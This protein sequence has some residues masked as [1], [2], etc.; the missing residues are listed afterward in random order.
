[1]LLEPVRE[2]ADARLGEVEAE[3]RVPIEDAAEEQLLDRQDRQGRH[4]QVARQQPR[5]RRQVDA[6]LELERTL[7]L[8]PG[9]GVRLA[10]VLPTEVVMRGDGDPERLRGRPER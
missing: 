8:G 9:Q 7:S 2:P 5:E 3:L 10:L 4:R 1:D 6:A